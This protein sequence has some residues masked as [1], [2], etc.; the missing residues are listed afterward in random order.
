M[1]NRII[2]PL[3]ALIKL[4]LKWVFYAWSLLTIYNV[5]IDKYELYTIEKS[6]SRCENIENKKN[7]INELR[8]EFEA[9]KVK[10]KEGENNE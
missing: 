4:L 7:E 9:L 6:E 10:L 5:G 8:K 2:S 1:L 3:G